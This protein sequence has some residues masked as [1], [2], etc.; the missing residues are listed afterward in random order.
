MVFGFSCARSSYSFQDGI[1]QP[2]DLGKRAAELGHTHLGICDTANVMAAVKLQGACD[3][4]GLLPIFGAA[5]WV[6]DPLPSFSTKGVPV[7]EMWISSGFWPSLLSHVNSQSNGQKTLLSH[8]HL[9]KWWGEQTDLEREALL[10]KYRGSQ[11]RPGYLLRIL[12]QNGIGW[13]NLGELISRASSRVFFGPSLALGDLGELQ[14]GLLFVVGGKCSPS[15]E[16]ADRLAATVNTDNLFFS[17]EDCALPGEGLACD[18]TR[19]TAE[20]L[21]LSHQLIVAPQARYAV[22]KQ[23]PFLRALHA[24]ATGLPLSSPALVAWSSDQQDLKSRQDLTDLFPD[25][26][27]EIENTG[28]MLQRCTH[29]LKLGT[30]FLPLTE[31][32]AEL[33]Q[34]KSRWM[35]MLDNFPPPRSWKIKRRPAYPKDTPSDESVSETYFRWYVREGTRQRFAAEGIPKKAQA[36]YLAQI[37]KDEYPVILTSRG[38]FGFA[39]YFLI[40]AEFINWA[41]DNDIPIGP[42]RGSAAGSVCSW[43][44]QI[45]DL[46]PIRY[47]LIFERFLNPGRL[48]GGG[49]PDI[50]VDVSQAGRE[51]L[52]EHIRDKYGDD[53]VGQIATVMAY[54]LKVA[55]TDM[56]R[57]LEFHYGD[58][59]AVTKGILSE[60]EKHADAMGDKRVQNLLRDPRFRYAMELTEG[61]KGAFRGTSVH[62][63]GVIIT[64]RPIPEIAPLVRDAETGRTVVGMDMNDAESIGLV[65]FDVLGLVNLDILQQAEKE[66]QRMEGTQ[67]QFHEIPLDD[68]ASL[69]LLRE[70]KGLGLFQVESDGMRRLLTRIAPNSIDDIIALVALYRPGPLMTGMVDDFI[71]RKHGRQAVSYPLPELEPILKETYGVWVYQEQIQRAAQLLAG[72]TLGEADTL[73][74]AVAKKKTKEMAPHKIRFVEGG[75]ER[76]HPREALERIWVDFEGFASY[77]FNKAHSACYGLITMLTAWYKTHHPD[78]YMAAVMTWQKKGKPEAWSSRMQACVSEAQDAGVEVLP[79]HVN[80]SAVPFQVEKP[81]TIRWGLKQIKGLGEA[82]ALDLVSE[83]ERSGPFTDAEDFGYRVPKRSVNKTALMALIGAGALDGLNA[84][85]HLIAQLARQDKAQGQTSLFAPQALVKPGVAWDW[86]KRLQAEVLAIGVNLSGSPMDRYTALEQRVREVST[87]DLADLPPNKD[88]V[89]VGSIQ[90]IF[91]NRTRQGDEMA[92]VHLADRKGRCRLTLF[93]MIWERWK[94]ELKTGQCI[95]VRGYVQRGA[96][97]QGFSVRDIR[98]LSDILRY[99]TSEL[100]LQLELKDLEDKR[101]LHALQECLKRFPPEE[102]R[103]GAAVYIEATRPDVSKIMLELPQKVA[104]S[105]TLLSELEVLFDRHGFVRPIGSLDGT[106][107]LR[108]NPVV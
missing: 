3:K 38:G 87:T 49:L 13:S 53:N 99:S 36:A 37:E 41:K 1:C 44:M 39:S 30:P 33:K 11:G 70:G 16:E 79:P 19:S 102:G 18:N 55:Y 61:L 91:K 95:A 106:Q 34:P 43:A 100:R 31:P 17:L 9:K 78:A 88:V 73:R 2:D 107:A 57:A 58:T 80:K 20:R 63:G 56:A 5:L 89:L 47:D 103:A 105:E 26:A 42:G 69:A 81:G 32:P 96:G 8:D 104:P 101:K 46:D 90:Q 15:D 4:Y 12:V 75:V 10:L 92:D 62:A 64:D 6:V 25:W 76:G 29:R 45:T 22:P 85:R 35:W 54:S 24:S 50:D 7:D 77:S 108:R 86:T 28:A 84:P 60:H 98:K 93:P 83:R 51:R 82:P 48:K 72:Y 59:K 21:G 94:E 27:K 68:E 74:R 14:E 52:I 40:V 65:K 67:R 23:A 97:H 71:E 66:I